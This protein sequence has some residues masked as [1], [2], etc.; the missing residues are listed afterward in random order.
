MQRCKPKWDFLELYAS[1]NLNRPE[2]TTVQIGHT[3]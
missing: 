2:L 3:P 1:E